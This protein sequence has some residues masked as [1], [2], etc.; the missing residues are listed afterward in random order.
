MDT[1]PLF[2]FVEDWIERVSVPDTTGAEIQVLKA[3]AIY[4]ARGILCSL[5]N[6]P[7]NILFPP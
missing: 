7:Y 4:V 6:K 3:G 1:R 2:V 5:R